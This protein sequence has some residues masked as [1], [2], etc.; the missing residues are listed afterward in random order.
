[1]SSLDVL[2]AAI[3]VRTD[4]I[5]PPTAAMRP[6]QFTPTPSDDDTASDDEAAQQAVVRRS[7]KGSRR[8]KRVSSFLL[9]CLD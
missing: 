3:D 4:R 5:L 6:G 2:L 9:P 7:S 8:R 1:M